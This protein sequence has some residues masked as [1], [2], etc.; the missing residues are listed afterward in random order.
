M[1][2]HNLFYL[3]RASKLVF[4]FL[5]RSRRWFPFFYVS[6]GP[7]FFGLTN[8]PAYVTIHHVVW[9]VSFIGDLSGHVS[10][11]ASESWRVLGDGSYNTRV[12]AGV[13]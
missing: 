8:K 5:M 10:G 12:W 4:K 7:R 3:R 9:R 11:Q 6:Q 2:S 13:M 1:A